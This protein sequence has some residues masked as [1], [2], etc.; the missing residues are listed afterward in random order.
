M[1]EI[2]FRGKDTKTKEWFYG[3]PY[4]KEIFSTEHKKI[5]GY[6]TYIIT[7]LADDLRSIERNEVDP[8]TLGQFTGLYDKNGKEIYDGDKIRLSSEYSICGSIPREGIVVW[9][10]DK[11]MYVIVQEENINDVWHRHTELHKLPIDSY[12]IIGNIH[13]KE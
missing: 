3:V 12:E 11:L 8:N 6:K 9:L 4:T 5:I 2:K 13:D 10:N 1:R 7:Y